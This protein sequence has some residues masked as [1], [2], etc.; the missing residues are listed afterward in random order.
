MRCEVEDCNRDRKC[1][2]WC[3]MHY[4]RWLKFGDPIKVAAGGMLH[5]TYQ[6]QD[7]GSLSVGRSRVLSVSGVPLEGNRLVHVAYMDESGTDPKEP[8]LVQAAIIAHGDKQLA[9]LRDCLH[10]VVEKHIPKKH[11][12]KFFFHAAEIYGGGGKNSIFRDRAEW[13]DERRF[14]ILDDLLAIPAK[15]GLP[16]CVGITNKDDF[17]KTRNIYGRSQIEI[18]V[19]MHAMAIIQCEIG[20]ELWMRNNTENE[21][22]H[23]VAEDNNDVRNAAREAH[24]YLKDGESLAQE[25]V[26]NSSVFPF[27]R[28]IDE[29]FF[30]SKAGCNALQ[31]ADVCAWACRRELKNV[32][33]SKRFYDPISPMI[34]RLSLS[35]QDFFEQ[36]LS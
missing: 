23:V 22:I 9:P 20:I 21:F 34:V 31:V 35:D 14:S 8:L 29:L 19:G 32:P 28:I 30:A 12:T 17:R 3:N 27:V 15:I 16:L 5:L 4:K 18:T 36:P 33:G 6:E 26:A 1:L 24:L 13:P 11:R 25:R 2:T 7:I 10:E